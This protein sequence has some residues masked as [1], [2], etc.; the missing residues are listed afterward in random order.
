MF[1]NRSFFIG[2][3][4]FSLVGVCCYPKFLHDGGCV[5]GAVGRRPKA[6]G[7]NST[8]EYRF[9]GP[10]LNDKIEEHRRYLA[11]SW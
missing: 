8:V 11:I 10:P 1:R 4:H 3:I 9:G 5:H 6:A 7:Q 2:Y